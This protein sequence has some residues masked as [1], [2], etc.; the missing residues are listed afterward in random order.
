VNQRENTWAEFAVADLKIKAAEQRRQTKAQALFRISHLLLAKP[1]NDDPAARVTPHRCL[2]Q[3]LDQGIF[4][5]HSD[6]PYWPMGSSGWLP[7]LYVP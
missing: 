7:G 5:A 3:H 6:S 1:L 4:I 2:A